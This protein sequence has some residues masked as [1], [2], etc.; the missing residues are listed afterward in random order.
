MTNKTQTR[1]QT[2]R[3]SAKHIGAILRIENRSFDFPWTFENFAECLDDGCRIKVAIVNK[4]V[5]GFVIFKRFKSCIQILNLA[6]AERA[7]RKGVGKKLVKKLIKLLSLKCWQIQTMIRESNRS[8][9][10]F[11][12]SQRFRATGEIVRGCYEET[13]D[14]VFPFQYQLSRD[15]YIKKQKKR[16]HRRSR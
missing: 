15:D 3:F 12:R 1:I 11:F 2:K 13:P 8:A 14:D 9:I 6:V 16:L 4:R 10:E 5:A 7:R